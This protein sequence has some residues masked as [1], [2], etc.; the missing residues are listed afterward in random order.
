MVPVCLLEVGPLGLLFGL[1]SSR[2]TSS[3]SLALFITGFF[4][5]LCLGCLGPERAEEHF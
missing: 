5:E 3:N 4:L 1:V 2:A